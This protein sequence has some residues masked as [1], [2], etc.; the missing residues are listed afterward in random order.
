MDPQD[1]QEPQ[2]PQDKVYNPAPW[3]IQMGIQ[4]F[5]E[6]QESKLNLFKFRREARRVN[7][8]VF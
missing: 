4:V 1:P 3:E 6:E 8:S 5:L 7:L 2:K